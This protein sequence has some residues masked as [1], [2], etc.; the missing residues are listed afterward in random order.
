MVPDGDVAAS[1]SIGKFYSVDDGF[2]VLVFSRHCGLTQGIPSFWIGWNTHNDIHLNPLVVP[3]TCYRLCLTPR[4]EGSTKACIASHVSGCF[5]PTR[6]LTIICVERLSGQN[7]VWH[8]DFA[9]NVRWY[10]QYTSFTRLEP[11]ACVNI[12]VSTFSG[13]TAAVIFLHPLAVFID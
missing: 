5:Y 3:Y 12:Y 1:P 4:L 10:V 2:Y 7:K 13:T 9:S 8:A 6:S 11:S